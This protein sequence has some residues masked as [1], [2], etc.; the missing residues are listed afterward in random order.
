MVVVRQRPPTAS[1]VTFLSLEDE[2]GLVDIILKPT[3]YDRYK[4]LLRGRSLL[5]VQGVI[6]RQGRAVS[7]LGDVVQ[8]LNH[9]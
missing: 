4:S 8:A 3:V 1:G 5:L 2:S 6:Q 7:L 9:T